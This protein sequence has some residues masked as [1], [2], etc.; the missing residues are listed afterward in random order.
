MAAKE[1]VFVGTFARHMFSLRSSAKLTS[2]AY[3]K[4]ASQKKRKRKQ[5]CRRKAVTSSR[6]MFAAA[7]SKQCSRCL[8]SYIRVTLIRLLRAMCVYK[9]YEVLTTLLCPGTKPGLLLVI[10]TIKLVKPCLRC[11]DLL[12]RLA[13]RLL[14]PEIVRV[15]SSSQ[16]LLRSSHH[17]ISAPPS[18]VK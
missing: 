3:P 12:S 4:I 11:R 17:I 18:P 2:F 7:I 9:L 16:K 15:A 13:T 8:L 1:A 14:P 5:F 10:V 6:L